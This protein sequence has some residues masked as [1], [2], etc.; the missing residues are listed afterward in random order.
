MTLTVRFR[1][2]HPPI[3]TKSE[4]PKVCPACG[5]KRKS[6]DLPQPRVSGIARLVQR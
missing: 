4:P 6:L 1:C 2:E 5:A 3:Q